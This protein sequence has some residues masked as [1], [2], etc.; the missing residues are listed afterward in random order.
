MISE[1][2][3]A[4]ALD[5][6]KTICREA[7]PGLPGSRQ[8]QQRAKLIKRALESHL[9]EK[10][11]QVEAFQFAPWAY[12]GTYPISAIFL[13][14]SA[15]TNFSWD[16]FP[17]LS[18]WP[19]PLIALLL[20][21][22]SVLVFILEFVL[23]FEVLDPLFGKKQSVNVI[24]TLQ[25]HGTGKVRKLLIFSGHHDSAPENA[26]LRLL[27]YGFFILSGTFFIGI[28]LTLVMN[29]ILLSGLIF[30][31]PGRVPGAAD[32]LS[33]CGL[34]AA[35]SRILVSHPEWIPEDT[36]IRFV[37]FGSEEAGYRGSKRY[38]KRHLDEL[39]RLDTRLVNFETVAHPVITVLSS[40][41]NGTVKNSPDF[42]AS[43]VAA[44][45]RSR[46]PY[47]VKPAF[48]GVANDSGPF[49]RA[50][51]KAATLLC[52]KMP[53]QFVAF[54]HQKEDKPENLTLEPF[55]N[56]LKLSLGWLADPG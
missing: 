47:R 46:I 39:K 6:V 12:V 8:E 48:M 4:Y 45:E 10:Q 20:S 29:M 13:F 11:V 27:G 22:I 28:L 2:D 17:G 3:A 25:G 40:D 31:S 38:V 19:I 52:F 44:A 41:Q 50:G 18:S 7:G 23:G 54:Y 24:G 37:S 53:Q 49:S 9:G 43:L 1:D 36:E 14:L 55:I 56:V 5:L 26:W 21:L 51:I 34:L 33:A 32:N 16:Y 35:L 30:T 15:L 42:I